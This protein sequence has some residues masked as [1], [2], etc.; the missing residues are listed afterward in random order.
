MLAVIITIV[1]LGVLVF[2]HEF[3]HFLLAKLNDVQVNEFAM[4]MGPKLFSRRR[5]E[6][7][8]S[9]R[10]FPVGGFVQ[11]EGEDEEAA[12]PRSFNA[13]RVWRRFLII[14]AGPLANFLVAALLFLIVYA[15]VGVPDTSSVIGSVMEGYP[16]AEAG[17]E[18]G[19]EIISING[20]AFSDW[21]GM[22][23]VIRSLAGEETEVVLLR[24][25]EELRFTLRIA[26]GEDGTGLLGIMQGTRR[27]GVFEAIWIGLQRTYELTRL[28]LVSLF[29]LITGQLE[30]DVAGPVGMVRIVGE[31]AKY[32]WQT[33]L[34]LAAVL[35][36]NFG[37]INL[38]PL[39]ALDGSRLVFL[40]VEGLR[41]KPFDRKREGMVHF[42]G[43]VAL[44]ALMII[45]TYHDIVSWIA[46]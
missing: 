34:N 40:I 36:I 27:P 45:I 4:G 44:M 31:Y 29:Q 35:S 37:V 7:T 17:I 33:V 42:I 32:G 26:T 8:Y 25:G 14:F 41:G 24:D 6:T 2:A 46:G 38:L 3:G 39:P 11:M 28:L 19:D 12:G 21:E 9:L 15:A 13:K 23:A 43:F 10:A 16:A 30:P 1:I 5:G 22:T 20:V 18:A